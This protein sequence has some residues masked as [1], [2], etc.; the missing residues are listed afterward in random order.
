MKNL[1]TINIIKRA[2]IYGFTYEATQTIEKVADQA[3]SYLYDDSA[4]PHRQEIADY[5]ETVGQST[6]VHW[7]DGMGF[8]YHGSGDY[9]DTGVLET[10]IDSNGFIV[11]LVRPSNVTP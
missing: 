11:D 9:P 4:V 5:V 10:V 7:E 6:V 3:A 8:V 2:C 1:R